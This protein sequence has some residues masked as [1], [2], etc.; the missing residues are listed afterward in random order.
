MKVVGQL[1]TSKKLSYFILSGTTCTDCDENISIYIYS[2]SDGPMTDEGDLQSYPYPGQETD[3]ESGKVD[4]E[5]RMFYGNCLPTHPNAVVWF[6]RTL[7]DDKKWRDDVLIAEV[8]NDD[9]V[10]TQLHSG[11]PKLSDAQAAVRTGQCHELPGIRT[12]GEP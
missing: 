4:Y 1:H 3:N 2:P 6:D 11:L 7:G 9:L 10:I 8:K 5:G 12:V